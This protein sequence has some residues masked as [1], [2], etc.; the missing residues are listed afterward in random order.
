MTTPSPPTEEETDMAAAMGFSAF[1]AQAPPKTKKRKPTH[2]PQSASGGNTIPLG[3]AREKKKRGT[4]D[5]KRAA[6]TAM[7]ASPSAHDASTL[8]EEGVGG[9]PVADD[10]DEGEEEEGVSSGKEEVRARVD[11]LGKAPVEGEKRLGMKEEVGFQGHSWRD[12]RMGVRYERGDV[13]FF[14]GSFVEDPW[15]GLRGREGGG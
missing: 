15:E 1:G 9:G 7:T 11:A 5:A 13:A 10:D 12:W 4:V 2:Q 14:D 3:K 6:D 8:G